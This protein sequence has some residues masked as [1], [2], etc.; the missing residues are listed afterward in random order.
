MDNDIKIRPIYYIIECKDCDADFCID[1]KKEYCAFDPDGF[2][3][4]AKATGA[5]LA[6][7]FKR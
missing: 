7:E 1:K 4:T 3:V 6:R 5:D 2:D